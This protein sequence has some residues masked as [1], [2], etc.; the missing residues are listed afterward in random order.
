MLVPRLAAILAV[1]STVM[2]APAVLAQSTPPSGSQPAPAQQPPAPAAPP[3]A[4]TPPLPP[5]PQQPGDAFGE[6]VT[7]TARPMIVM[8]GNATWDTAFDT[9]VDA[10]EAVQAYM[11]KQGIKPSGSPIAIYTSA[12][13]TGF[14]FE[15]GYPV[16]EAPKNAPTGDLGAIQCPE[17]RTLKYVHRGSYDTMDTTYEAITN[18]LDEKQLDAKDMFIE[19]YVTDPVKAPDDQLI[20]NI[21]VPIK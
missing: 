11:N 12:D 4:T 6:E 1:A 14:H 16:A 8:R 3:Q 20:I 5:P 15:A 18:H 17:G 10:F 19:E 9:L 21:Y 13:D 7:L 2:M